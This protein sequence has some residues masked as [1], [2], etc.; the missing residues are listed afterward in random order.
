MKISNLILAFVLCLALA[1]CKKDGTL[2]VTVNK[3]S[4]GQPSELALGATVLVRSIS[5]STKFYM[6]RTSNLGVATFN[7]V[8]QDSYRVSA[9]VWDGSAGLYDDEIV[10][11][12]TGKNSDVVLLLQ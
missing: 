10:G 4:A 9:Q 2:T 5:D 12:R 6:E 1:S 3:Q 11:V 8:K 7:D